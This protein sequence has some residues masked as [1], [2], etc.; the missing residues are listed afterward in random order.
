MTKTIRFISSL[1]LGISSI[2]IL[3]VFLQAGFWFAAPLLAVSALFWFF[4]RKWASEWPATAVML[5][6]LAVTTFGLTKQLAIPLLLLNS[7]LIVVFW[8]LHQFAVEIPAGQPENL[9][10]QLGVI[11]FRALAIMGAFTAALLFF[12]ALSTIKIP[13]G[14]V[15]ALTLF[16]VI[17]FVVLVRKVGKNT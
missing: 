1:T 6:L 9:T 3:A 12:A 11:H 8:D 16:L 10:R 17:G 14:W 5:L 4:T 13:F 15:M 7:I 2:V